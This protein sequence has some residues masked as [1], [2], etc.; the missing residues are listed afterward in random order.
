MNRHL[1]TAIL[2]FLLCLGPAAGRQASAWTKVAA[3]GGTLTTDDERVPVG[4]VAVEAQPADQ[5]DAMASV[6][7]GS[8][9]LGYRFLHVN[10]Q[11]GLA[12]Q[13]EY[14]HPS[15]TGNFFLSSLGAT[16]KVTIDG[17]FLNDK[18][19]V[20]ELAFDAQGKVR[21]HART[22]S[23]FHNLAGERLLAEPLVLFGTTTPLQEDR[24]T[25]YGIRVEQDL[26]E[27]RLKPF[28]YPFHFNLGYWR[29]VREGTSQL[30][31][32]DH[33][34]GTAADDPLPDNKLVAR[35]RQAALETH[36]GR[37]G[38]DAHMGYLDMVYQFQVRQYYDATAAPVDPFIDRPTRSAGLM[39][40]N[41]NPSSR[42]LSHTIKLHSSLT[43][44]LVGAAS[45]TY[46][47]R[48]LLD[49]PPTIA[50]AATNST[51]LH[52]LA[53]DLTYTPVNNLTMS[54]KYRH[55]EVDVDG[56]ASIVSQLAVPPSPLAYPFADPAG[57]LT[58]RNA[59][60]TRLDQVTVTAN[61]RPLPLLTVIGE[62]RGESRHRSG[63]GSA[64]AAWTL[65]EDT[66]THRGSLSVSS[67]PFKG[68]R[69]K[70]LYRYT[71]TDRPAYGLTPQEQHHGE[72]LATYTAA[73]QWGATASYRTDREWNNEQSL[74]TRSLQGEPVVV[75][76]LPR[77]RISHAATVGMWF[78]PV[79]RLTLSAGY[80]LL[81]LDIDQAS[82]LSGITPGVAA[83]GAFRSQNH[84]Y[85]FGTAYQ[86][87]EELNLS[88][89]FSQG[90][91][92]TEFT[93]QFVVG[94]G[95]DSSG[96]RDISRHR[97]VE[98]SLGARADYRFN[99]HFSC[100]TTYGITDYTDKAV[101][102]NNGT[103]QM[104]TV[105]MTANW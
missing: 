9:G 31:F 36:E 80:N 44:G 102:F 96:I 18:D 41:L 56:P 19:Y 54:I 38:L 15:L 97:L 42:F 1:C 32:A 34:F 45:Y 24:E 40:H 59:P 101:T 27:G 94:G 69:L 90:R 86:A 84:Y 8:A 43:G 25:R 53:G 78:S 99:R 16:R 33:G 92:R 35:L 17:N 49:A 82:L 83:P 93:P 21:L 61:Y 65:P 28:P 57:T 60:D 72:A 52:N 30:R 67:R 71:T 23:L 22:E 68:M 26:V 79:S 46:G 104:V 2:T 6:T 10:G 58:V 85:T 105:A 73:N 48:D 63:S 11:G 39:P 70:S 91:S 62:Y 3:D 37:I 7:T 76:L 89:T 51:T 4:V 95:G 81:R 66:A 55:Q 5:A 103:V 87:T 75:Y 74:P 100:A 98:T 14:L 88:L 12:A 50:G 47:R 20:G 13:Y 77:E 64:P 29:L